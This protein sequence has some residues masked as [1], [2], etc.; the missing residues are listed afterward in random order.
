VRWPFLFALLGCGGAG[1]GP[2]TRVL[3][4]A[5]ELQPE[6]GAVVLC[7]TA[8]GT[9]LDRQLTDGSGHVELQTQSGALVTVIYKRTALDVIT[10]P[11]LA[12]GELAIHGPP[13]DKAPIIAGALAL[14]APAI[15]ADRIDI[16]LGCTTVSVGAFPATVN[17]AATCLGTDPN[18]DVLVRASLQTPGDPLV[19]YFAARVPVVDEVAM[20]DIPAW[21]AAPAVVPITQNDPGAIVEVDEVADGLVY[22]T[23]PGI[24]HASAWTGLI[25]ETSRIRAQVGFTTAG[26]TTTRTVPGVPASVAFAAADFLPA[27]DTRVALRDRARL[28][29]GWTA[30]A[31]GDALD[32]HAVWMPSTAVIHWHAL[33]A[34]DADRIE[35]P[36]LDPDLAEL[37]A[38]P[39][40]GVALQTD[41]RAIDGPDTADFAS[42][43]AAGWWVQADN[44]A[45]VIPPPLAGDVRETNIGGY[46]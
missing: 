44:N 12:T 34:P 14:T 25:A 24:D 30:P 15:D 42:A 27:L 6:A 22:P 33:L 31:I 39:G 19:G 8:D 13:P 36:V 37:L 20:L 7:H 5:G 32:F 26:Q 10:T 17:I 45:T 18:I 46:D 28:S 35:F 2:T 43:Q 3:A 40:N 21:Q 9:I 1:D 29:F 38:P 16:D 41:L 4:L 11:A 23:P